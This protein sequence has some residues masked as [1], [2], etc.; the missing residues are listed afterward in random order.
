MLLDSN[1]EFN[2]ITSKVCSC[3]VHENLVKIEN[4][5][6]YFNWEF[7]IHISCEKERNMFA[8][9]CKNISIIWQLLQINHYS[10]ES[11]HFSVKLLS[12]CHLFSKYC[13]TYDITKFA[14]I[15]KH[16]VVVLHTAVSHRS[17]NTFFLVQLRVLNV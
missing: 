16:F 15:P 11:L 13:F 7:L 2:D 8:S 3:L 1:A 5:Y 12:T 9:S 10:Y 14:D 17:I 4:N 6:N